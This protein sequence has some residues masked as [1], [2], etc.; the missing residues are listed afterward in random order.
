MNRFQLKYLLC[1]YDLLNVSFTVMSV[2]VNI[3]NNSNVPFNV[4]NWNINAK[5]ALHKQ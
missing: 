1:I 4:L 3:V 5:V 2:L